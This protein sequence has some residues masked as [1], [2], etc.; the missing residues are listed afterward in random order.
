MLES[1]TLC[2]TRKG[3]LK[4]KVWGLDVADTER[5]LIVDFILV[6][7]NVPAS[8]F[9]LEGVSILVESTL[10]ALNSLASGLLA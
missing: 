8:D 9:K 1:N 7:W 5:Q 6:A 2:K 4:S 3:F 10:P